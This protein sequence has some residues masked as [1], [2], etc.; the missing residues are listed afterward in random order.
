MILGNANAVLDTLTFYFFN[1]QQILKVR[2]SNDK[3]SMLLDLA[4]VLVNLNAFPPKVPVQEELTTVSI[5]TSLT[6]FIQT[7]ANIRQV[8]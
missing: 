1:C 7:L 4:G 2:L 8:L 3:I 6:C 5:S